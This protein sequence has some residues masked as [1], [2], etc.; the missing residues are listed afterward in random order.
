MGDDTLED[1]FEFEGR[2]NLSTDGKEGF[3]AFL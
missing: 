3:E 2:G 1:F